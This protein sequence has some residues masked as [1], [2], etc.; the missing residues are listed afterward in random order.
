MSTSL[1]Q[2]LAAVLDV[3]GASLFGSDAK[4]IAGELFDIHGDA[5]LLE[6]EHEFKR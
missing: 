3:E 5:R 6:S 2:T 4:R 1:N